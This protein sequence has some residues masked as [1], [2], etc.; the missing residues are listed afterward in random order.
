MRRS[1]R[2]GAVVAA[3]AVSAALVASAIGVLGGGPAPVAEPVPTV[4]VTAPPQAG[5]VGAALVMAT[6]NVCKVSCEAPAPSWDVRRERVARVITESGLDVVGLQEVTFNPTAFAKT[7]F[8]DVQNLIRPAGFVA[9]TMPPAAD[10][11]RWTASNPHP[12]DHT[13]GIVFN[14]RTVS[15]VSTPNG[16]P[17]A[18]T[19]PS[20]AVASGLDPA[21][22]VRK[23]SWAYLQGNNGAG[24]F[25][26]LSIHTSNGKDGATEA[27]RV[28]LGQALGPWADAWNAA[29]GL[30]GAP[31]VMLGDLN[32]YKKRQPNGMQQVLV[33]TGWTDAASAPERR[34]VQYST[35]NHNPKL[36]ANEQGF[37]RA[38]YIF[39]TSRSNPVL[40][41]TRIDYVMARGA[42][43]SPAD[44]EVVIRLLPDGSFDPQYQ[45]SD[46]Q[47]VRSTIVFG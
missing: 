10:Q 24:P 40:D 35:I 32:S 14:T 27:S 8:L 38:P 7:Q 18:G 43:L 36:A 23:I 6:F 37:P 3:A 11:C 16:S 13:T 30:A 29:H 33:Q 41:A 31:T 44:Y 45:A 19:L 17:S 46:H 12:C 42:T 2:V 4:A 21:S 39:R 5:T 9:P 25:L 34:N 1:T 20:S 22:A 26:V 15:Q 28:A 47:M